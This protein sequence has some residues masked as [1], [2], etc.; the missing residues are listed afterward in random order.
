M[1]SLPWPRTQQRPQ[2]AYA[3]VKHQG[4]GF[5]ELRLYGLGL[6]VSGDQTQHKAHRQ[7]QPLAAHGV[8]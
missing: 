4:L 6:L 3:D 1:A 8:L 2:K 7:L 5:R